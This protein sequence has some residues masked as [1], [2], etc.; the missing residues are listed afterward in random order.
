MGLTQTAALDYFKQGI[1][2]NAVLPG[3][4]EMPMALQGFGHRDNW[5]ATMSTT[6][7]G[8]AGKPRWWP[9]CRRRASNHVN[10]QGW[11]VDGGYTVQ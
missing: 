5:H 7:A 2:V 3:P 11:F 6:A 9:S 10:G 1:R 8:R 4:V